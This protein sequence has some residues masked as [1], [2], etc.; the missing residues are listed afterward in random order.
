MFEAAI[1]Q[2]LA[3]RTLTDF[4]GSLAGKYLAPAGTSENSHTI[5]VQLTFKEERYG[6]LSEYGS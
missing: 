5:S 2:S 1:L 3:F 4:D 6:F